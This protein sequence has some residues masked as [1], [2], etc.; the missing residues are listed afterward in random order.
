[1]LPALKISTFNF[2]TFAGASALNPMS[3]ITEGSFV[4]RPLIDL[5]SDAVRLAGVSHLEQAPPDLRNAAAKASLLHCIFSLEC[6]ANCCLASLDYSKRLQVAADRFQVLEKF[7]FALVHFSEERLDRGRPEVQSVAELLSLRNDYV[8]PKVRSVP[9]K[10]SQSGESLE[11]PEETWPTLGIAKESNRWNYSDAKV[12]LLAVDAFLTYYLI[13]LSKFTLSQTTT[14]LLPELIIPSGPQ[15]AFVIE[16]R[17]ALLQAREGML[18]PF[19]FLNLDGPF[20]S[21]ISY[22]SP[23]LSN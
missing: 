2:A 11:L 18:I 20:D 3:G 7:E 10:H 5:L 21:E 8:H 17:E 1:M 14:L 22:A 6:A 19:A 9:A 13:T 12:G 16:H 4:H 15:Y 23:T